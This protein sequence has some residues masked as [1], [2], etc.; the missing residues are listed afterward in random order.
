MAGCPRLVAVDLV[1][2]QVVGAFQ[3]GL[4]LP[5][6]EAAKLIGDLVGGDREKVS[7]QFAAVVK[8]GQAIE[9]ADERLLDDVLA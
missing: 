2:E 5:T 9:E 4:V 6:T 7:L 1:A 3:A 8:V